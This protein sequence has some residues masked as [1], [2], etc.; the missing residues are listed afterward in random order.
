MALT[1]IPSGL[2]I[3]KFR[4]CEKQVQ[5]P[6]GRGR[7]RHGQVAAETSV[8]GESEEGERRRSEVGGEQ[9]ARSLRAWKTIARMST[10]TLNERGMWCRILSREV[11]QPGHGHKMM[12][13]G[14]E[15]KSFWLQSPCYTVSTSCV[16]WD[17]LLNIS[18]PEF[19][20]L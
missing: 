17:R 6:C 3:V 13:C 1:K 11:K 14:F 18:G 16:T 7:A 5:R 8:T 15:L 9:A 12:K 2:H 10:F 20:H 19:S 4:R